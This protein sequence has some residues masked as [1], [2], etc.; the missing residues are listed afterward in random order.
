MSCIIWF[1]LEIISSVQTLRKKIASQK[2]ASIKVASQKSAS[3]KVASQKSASDQKRHQI[4]P[5][6]KKCPN[7]MFDHLCDAI[8][9]R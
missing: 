8:H 5:S 6:I 7:F 2:S 9:L 3:I 4:I 1:T